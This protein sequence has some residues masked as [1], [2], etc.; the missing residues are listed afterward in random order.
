MK[1]I[2]EPRDIRTG[3]KIN[4]SGR[5]YAISHIVHW[6][7]GR[8]MGNIWFMIDLGTFQVTVTSNDCDN[9]EYVAKFL[10]ANNAK[11]TV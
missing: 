5:T 10:T 8:N 7:N 1:I 2:Y 3:L 9:G 4:M 6:E 11:V